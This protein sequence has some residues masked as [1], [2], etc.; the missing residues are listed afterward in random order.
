V[1][2]DSRAL[3]QAAALLAP[4]AP[5]PEVVNWGVDTERFAPGDAAA[6][7]ERVGIEAGG[8]VVMGIRGLATHYNPAALLRGFALLLEEVPEARLVL[9]H[10][11]NELP[12][13]IDAAVEKL[14]IEDSVRV[15]GHVDGAELADWYRAAD[16]CVSIPST[17]SSPRS[18]WEALACARP[19]VVSDLPWARE[20]L[21]DGREALLVPAR[22]EPVGDALLSLLHQPELTARLA[23]GG[24]ALATERMSRDTEMQRAEEVYRRVIG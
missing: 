9:K 21:E 18:V 10:P 13:E 3:A 8:P 4:D 1:L 14:G 7:R 20:W 19:L 12:V 17:D 16:V 2:A 23:E 24:R 5:E 11:Y 22:P 6:A 15:V